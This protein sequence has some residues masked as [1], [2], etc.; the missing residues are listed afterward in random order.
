MVQLLDPTQE[1]VRRQTGLPVIN[2]DDSFL[3]YDITTDKWVA[4]SLVHTDINDFDSGVRAN[5]LD[6]LAVPTSNISLN[7]NKITNLTDPTADQDAATK[8]YVDSVSVLPSLPS[9]N[10]W[11]GSGSGVAT[12][13]A[14]S[15][16]VSLLTAGSMTINS[17][18]VTFP[19]IQ[20]V[21]SNRFLGRQTT[22]SG[23]IEQL[24]GTQLTTGLDVFSSTLKGLAPFSGGGTANYLRADGTWAV[25][26]GTGIASLNG[27]TTAAQ[28]ITAGTNLS[29]VNSGATHTVNMATGLS[30]IRSIVFDNVVTVPAIT[31]MAIFK[32]A[33]NYI[34]NIPAGE[35]KNIRFNG[36][37]EYVY[38]SASFRLQGNE[39]W[40]Q[41]TVQ[42]HSTGA[43]SNNPSLA[44]NLIVELNGDNEYVFGRTSVDFNGNSLQ[45]APHNHTNA[46]GGGQLVAST[47]LTAS[48]TKDSTTFLRGDNTWAVPPSGGVTGIASINADTTAAQ[49]IAGGTNITLVD[50][51]ATH[52]LNLDTELD[53]MQSIIFN[54][55]VTTPPT[56][57]MALFRQN[58]NWIENIINGEFK[59]I[60]FG[61]TNEYVFSSNSF[62]LNNNE[63]WLRDTV[64]FHSTGT[65][66][67]NSVLSDNL[68]IELNETI[69]YSFRP[70]ELN[71]MGNNITNVGTVSTNILTT[72][73]T[74]G[75]TIRIGADNDYVFS[76]TALDLGGMALRNAP[77]NHTNA[78]NGGTLGLAALSATGTRNNTRYLRGDNT[79]ATLPTDNSGITTL[80]GLTGATQTFTDG[81]FIDITSSGTT[82]TIDLSATGTRNNTTYLRGDNTWASISSGGSISA[83]DGLTLTGT[84]MSITPGVQSTITGLGNQSQALHMN[85]NAIVMDD[86]G[87]NNTEITVGT[88]GGVLNFRVRGTTGISISKI[89]DSG[90]P[91]IILGQSVLEVADTRGFVRINSVAGTPTG[92]PAITTGTPLIWNSTGNT[93]HTYSGGSWN[94][95]G[96][97]G[98]SGITSLNG[99]TGTTQT[100]T[101]GTFIDI[102]SAGTTH[103]IDL[104]AT[105]TPSATTFLRGDNTWATPAGGGSGI[106]SLNGLTVGTQT[107]AGVGGIGITSSGTTHTFT[108]GSSI[109][110][111]GGT[112]TLT[113]KTLTT[114]TIG[115]FTNSTHDHSDNAG[116]GSLTNTALTAGTY[117]NI[118]GLGDLTQNLR[119]IDDTEMIYFIPNDP[120][121]P[122]RPSQDLPFYAYGVHMDTTTYDMEF[123]TN[124]NVAKF[125]FGLANTK[126][127]EVTSTGLNSTVN[128]DLGGNSLQN[129]PHNHTNALGGG[130]L[131]LTAL[132]ATGTRNNTT[133]LRGDNTW[134]TITAGGS[135]ITSLGGLTGAVQTFTDGTFIDITSSGTSHTIDLN[136]TGTPS[137][138]TFL[139]GDNTWATVSGDGSGI[140]SLNGLAAFVQ[141]FT[142]VGGI[143]ITSSG[144]NH[145][146]TIGSS[147]V[148]LAGTQT[149]TNKTLTTPTISNFANATHNHST[150]ANG[151]S[152]GLSA[153]S[154][155][156]TRNNTTYLRGD[157]IW[158]TLPTD[159]AGI[160]SL[161][162]LTGAVQ[163][164]TNGTFIDVTSSGTTHTIDLNATG[165]ASATTFL[166]G[167]NSWAVPTSG[168]VA[169][170]VSINADTTA[171]QL[172]VGGTNIN[173]VDSGA[174]HTFNLDT[175]MTG[176]QSM[177]F[178]NVSTSPIGS[179]YSIYR[180]GNT[181]YHNVPNGRFVTFRWG[182]SNNYV[183]STSSL[184]LGGNELW[185]EDSVQLHSTGAN[186]DNPSLAHNLIVELNGANEYVFGTSGVD[187]NGNSL[188]NAPHNHTNV[189]NGGTLGLAALSASG[190]RNNTTYLRGDNTW[191]T[192]SGGSGITSL[193]GL[194]GST[195]TFTGAGNLNIASAGNV[196][197]FSLSSSV[198]TIAGT[199]TLTNKTLTNPT[200]ASF[201]NATHSHIN[202]IS[203]GKLGLSALSAT[204][205]RDSTTFLRG[206]NTWAT[207]SGGGSGITSLNALTGPTQTFAGAG[208]LTISSSGTVHTLTAPSRIHNLSGQTGG[209][210]TLASGTGITVSSN[211][212]IHTFSLETFVVTTTG[213]QTLSNKVLTTPTVSSFINATHNHSSAAT[214]GLISG[215]QTS[216]TGIGEQSQ[217]LDMNTNNILDIGT[218]SFGTASVD[219][220]TTILK[221][222]ND[223]LIFN[224][225]GYQGLRL[226]ESGT[227]IDTIIGKNAELALSATSGHLHIPTCDG[228][229][230]G[231]PQSYNG[232]IPIIYDKANDD[233]FA[234]NESQWNTIG[235]GGGGGT[236]RSAGTG[237]SLSGNSL[238]IS[239]GTH[240]EI[241]GIGV[242]AQD[243]VM[244]GND[245]IDTSQITFGTG[246]NPTRIVSSGT[247]IQIRANSNDNIISSIG[248]PGV[249]SGT[250]DILIGGSVSSGGNNS[251][252]AS[253]FLRIP[254]SN[255]ANPNGPYFGGGVP[256]FMYRSGTTIRLYAHTGSGSEDGWRYVTIDSS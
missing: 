78:L 106:A 155:S 221:D 63:F 240:I 131:G 23:N 146:F 148:T 5:R 214:G 29:I 79:W 102:T 218:I 74:G 18:A 44:H 254:L 95:I 52:T 105:G 50:S 187:F 194:T 139:R 244:N 40:L 165:T 71:V 222:E 89:I 159:N 241:T 198:A 82:H 4:K 231:T 45:N 190:T 90:D 162:G 219:D 22:G 157:N 156:G 17:D 209:T 122:N 128:L 123:T 173:L 210:Q 248:V 237:L 161:G 220:F 46:L 134:A 247:D 91:D 77:H 138:T 184:R 36:V 66:A 196:H 56:T 7:S 55:V 242:Q 130:Q 154:A 108:I 99:L 226:V 65:N 166:R 62:R 70:T 27:D 61:G 243:L 255:I 151:G 6:Q 178:T 100:F 33:G 176:I 223:D 238:N 15:G 246:D 16:D 42:L 235:G 192:V 181:M 252:Y 170:L 54:N 206:D 39:L 68:N 21:S 188:Q 10:I 19:K 144:A 69:E 113:N 28:L 26:T 47:A 208:G 97:G 43:N 230:T 213:A 38:N 85:D 140:T 172:F 207:V 1:E 201:T 14:I 87:G 239:T 169:G 236:P 83:G 57:S 232:K 171:A 153:L 124:F 31:T 224:V 136:A 32:Q 59:V 37:N 229:P 53:A 149:L 183:F 135:G 203:G 189:L 202:N 8:A 204:G 110:T 129:A 116:G 126:W 253:G 147:I 30:G 111:L 133:Y 11:I 150:N 72:A 197:T 179:S 98:G 119:F 104:T 211:S 118:T 152:L 86:V 34:E 158:A 20:N 185:L 143:G 216:I 120:T 249:N 186:A 200:I 145:T 84:V 142:G 96:G 177:L 125:V 250:P 180:S 217:A 251:S 12:A 25:P 168:G 193:N 107:F 13:R 137:A 160:T 225:A 233:L 24:T 112:Q 175:T 101:D 195:Q 115:S 51:G 3:Q 167:D 234:Y 9:G 127:F 227:E 103:T 121:D 58:G 80:N 191:A 256:I 2:L 212:N 245:I 88:F 114:P 49:I 41:D 92:T 109:A 141:T 199:Q 60:R 182:G 64:Q 132:S 67:D 35:F 163:T 76:N 205:T 228:V 48:G 94:T 174:T 81:T 73:A 164:F 215:N 93:L 117:S 75:L